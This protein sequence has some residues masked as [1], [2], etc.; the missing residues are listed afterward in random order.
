MYRYKISIIYIYIQSVYTFLCTRICR[1]VHIVLYIRVAGVPNML[2]TIYGY[3]IPLDNVCS[4][5]LLSQAT[6]NWN[7]KIPPTSEVVLQTTA[8]FHGA[9]KHTQHIHQPSS[10][11]S[12]NT[13]TFQHISGLSLTPNYVR[14][15]A[16][17]C[18]CANCKSLSK[19]LQSQRRIDL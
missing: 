7:M 18:A 9:L 19:V 11:S 12:F 1:Y 16:T 15:S 8:P 2:H 13:P 3:S 5:P 17:P 14:H 6:K 4:C 10:I